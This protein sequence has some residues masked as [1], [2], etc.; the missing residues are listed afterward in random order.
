MTWPRPERRLAAATV[1]LAALALAGCAA[2]AASPS[3]TPDD[4]GTVAPGGHSGIAASL[5]EPWSLPAC[6]VFWLTL[7]QERASASEGLPEGQH[8]YGPLLTASLVLEVHR[9]DALVVG[10]RSVVAPFDW[11]VVHHVLNDTSGGADLDTFWRE[12]LVSDAAVAARLAGSGFPASLATVEAGA[13]GEARVV[14][15]VGVGLLYEARWAASAEDQPS[16]ETQVEVGHALQQDR[17]L[18]ARVARQETQASSPSSLPVVLTAEGGYLGPA[19]AG[20]QAGFVRSSA[21]AMAVAFGEGA[22]PGA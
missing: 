10:N 13:D 1:V 19:L 3:A 12:V 9:C 18:W 5:E 22:A 17:L 11:A 16:D 6:E 21:A 8:A 4:L 2:P 15:V 7:Q 20:G 14:R